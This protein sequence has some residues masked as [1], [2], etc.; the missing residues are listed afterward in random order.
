MLQLI[1]LKN[2]IKQ[3][4]RD[5]IMA[6]MLVAP[7]FLIIVFK[8]LIIFLI[9]FIYAQTGF[10]VSPYSQYI[11][12]SV[13]LINSGMLGIVTGFM[14]IDERDGNIAELMS[15]T[16]LGMSGYL[17][18]RLSFASILSV[19]YCIISCYA[20]NAVG[21]ALASVLFLSVLSAIY[22]AIIGLLIFSGADN[23]VKGLTYA[24]ALNALILFAFTDLFSLNWLTWLSWFFPPY[25]ITMIIKSPHSLLIK[26]IALLVHAGW[27]WILILRYWRKKS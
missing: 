7:L 20:L 18:N 15:I 11:L 9:P 1:H 26:G 24:K 5:P 8:L 16:P 2:D 12:A 6:I 27:L 4:M 23:K 14:M 13:L 21:L 19:T 17:I 25:W 10:D 22:S 3:I